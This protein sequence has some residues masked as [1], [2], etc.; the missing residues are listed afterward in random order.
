[1][2]VNKGCRDI[3]NPRYIGTSA[4]VPYEDTSALGNTGTNWQ[5]TILAEGH[6]GHG[7]YRISSGQVPT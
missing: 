7:Y 3:L 4:E 5:Q 2:P 6:I 1:V